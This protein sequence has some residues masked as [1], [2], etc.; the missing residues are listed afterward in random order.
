VLILLFI[1][2]GKN[3]IKETYESELAGRITSKVEYKGALWVRL[4]QERHIYVLDNSANYDLKERKLKY[5]LEL[6]DS[7]YKPANSDSLYIY[8]KGKCYLFMLGNLTFNRDH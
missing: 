7:I 3:K 4:N 1:T 5:F 6:E 8:R 2:G